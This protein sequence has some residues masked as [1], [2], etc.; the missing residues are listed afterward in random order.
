[1]TRSRLLALF[2]ALVVVGGS[3]AGGW[4]WLANSLEYRMSQIRTARGQG[5]QETAE[6]LLQ[7]LL[8]DHGDS[9]EVRELALDVARGSEDADEIL[10]QLTWLAENSD[11]PASH[12]RE[13]ADLRLEAG[14]FD[15]A[16]RWYR[17]SL[18][19]DPE[20]TAS[21]QRLARLLSNGGRRWEAYPLYMQIIRMGRFDLPELL[22]V[23]RTE[24][25]LT[26][27]PE[28]IAQRYADQSQIGPLLGLARFG[29]A[30]GSEKTSEQLL[31]KVI[32]ERPE[33]VEAHIRLAE[34]LL[35][36][37]P[38]EFVKLMP[39]LPAASREH[40][41][42]W[43][44][45][46][47]WYRQNKEPKAAVA[48]FAQALR[49]DANR[50]V[51]TFQLGQ[52]LAQLGHEKDAG[53]FRDRAERLNEL[54]A[55]LGDFFAGE[56]SLEKAQIAS[57]QLEELG[58]YWEA[59]AWAQYALSLDS[60]DWSV[61][62][63]QRINPVLKDSLPIVRH[64][65]N[66]V[67]RLSI[68]DWPL[69][70]ADVFQRV[71]ATVR[72]PTS[73][74]APDFA[75]IQF[76]DEAERLG[77]TFRYFNGA[78]PASEEHRMYE[79]TGGGVGVIDYDGDGAPDLYFPNGTRWPPR[80][81]S[82]FND[83]FFR[84]A[85]SRFEDVAQQAGIS[86][87]GFGQGVAVGDIDGDGFADIYVANTHRNQLWKNNGDGTF[88][89]VTE[90]AGLTDAV[91]T[92]SCL[93]ADL[94]GDGLPDIYDVNF[95]SGDDVFTRICDEDGRPRSCPPA[96]FPGEQDRVLLNRSDGT[97][98]DQT[99][100][101]GIVRPRG[102]GLGI[103]AADFDGSRRLNLFIA[104]DSVP[105]FYYRNIS[106]DAQIEFS[107]SSVLAGLDVDHEGQ[108]QACMGVGIADV[109]S[110]GLPDL[111]ITNFYN[112]SNALYLQQA[113][114][115][116]SDECRSSNVRDLSRKLLGFGT[117]FLDV[118]LNGY[119]DLV[120]TNGHVDDFTHD[121]T[122]YQMPPQI[123]RHS[124]SPAVRFFEQQPQT[125]EDGYFAG[126]YL[127]RG[128]ARLDFDGDGV[129]D[130]AVSHLDAP[131]ALVRN[132]TTDKGRSVSVR[133]VS[134]DAA[135][136]SIGAIVTV[137]VGDHTFAQQLTAGDGY[138]ASNE[139]RLNIGLGSVAGDVC[140]IDVQWM[141]GN[142][143]RFPAVTIGRRVV[144]VEGSGRPLFE[145]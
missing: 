1:M 96:E 86:E 127:G 92:T 33:I 46:G 35:E 87:S 111:F 18:K 12:A 67:R 36:Q 66:P 100:T 54:S 10:T 75:P 117:Q 99:E 104:N 101:A 2:S 16:E 56:G 94:N 21:M 109:D 142:T 60:L 9:V 102:N 105:N 30:T 98:A 107:E 29:M 37:R 82:E 90:A 85:G 3:I 97:F 128:L 39:Q 61:K 122:P 113:E 5:E 114:N 50:T 57:D 134:T 48:A 13:I 17:A 79:F 77:L 8:R 124:G 6:R 51:A 78:V 131:V 70:G 83:G 72:A 23:G 88:T 91:W 65:F 119:P 132:G 44:I 11:K 76:E 42:Y 121:A 58:R 26:L 52:L 145:P 4:Y 125:G 129:D 80:E 115:V 84:N 74:G 103:I 59:A 123:L 62:R 38:A 141:S 118:D 93:I 108:S 116:F 19:A 136:E 69:P 143:E 49:I 47:K 15:D 130:F 126:K 24:D 138:M 28:Y 55:T 40:P 32:Q 68:E 144:L 110:N 20:D 120:V 89:D 139:R 137:R 31:R 45:L 43:V 41:A 34:L 14:L 135:R 53:E 27:Q 95:L 22:Y 140:E 106:T 63:L 7:P 73:P 71:A 64:D 81:P 112:E 25:M 133:L